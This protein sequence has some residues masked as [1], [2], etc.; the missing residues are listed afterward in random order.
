MNLT[1]LAE[2]RLLELMLQN[3]AWA[4][5]GDASGLQPSGAAGSFY[6]ALFTANPGEGGSTTAEATYTSYARVAVI[7]SVGGWAVVGSLGDNAALISFP[8]ATGGSNTLTHLAFMTAA[9]GGDMI[10]FGA[11]DESIIVSN[12]IIPNIQ[13]G[14]LAVTAD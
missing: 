13:I 10:I 4:N 11:L 2:Q 5:I 12:G 8:E 9:S 3:I 6:I 14:A 7:R 1:N